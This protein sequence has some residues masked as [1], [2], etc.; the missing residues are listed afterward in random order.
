MPWNIKLTPKTSLRPHNRLSFNIS[1]HIERAMIHRPILHKYQSAYQD[2]CV[3]ATFA[4]PTP[5]QSPTAA[6]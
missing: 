5:K 4:F 1:C 6:V 3:R 2:V